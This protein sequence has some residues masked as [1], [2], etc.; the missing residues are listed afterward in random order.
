MECGAVSMYV[1]YAGH[2]VPIL[3]TLLLVEPPLRVPSAINPISL[4]ESHLWS[5]KQGIVDRLNS[6]HELLC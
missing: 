3:G 4:I 6:Q 1:T 5:T 2:I